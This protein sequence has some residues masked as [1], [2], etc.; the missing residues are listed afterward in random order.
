MI[1]FSA[2]PPT[3]EVLVLEPI[4]TFINSL[5]LGRPVLFVLLTGLVIALVSVTG[6][7]LTYWAARMGGRALIEKLARR[8]WLRLDPRRAERAESL[9]A[10]WG[11][12]LVVFGRIFPGLRTLVSVPAGL[13][14]IPFSQFAGA[15]FIG[16]FAWNTLLVCA[17]YLL[18]FKITL[19]GVSIL[20]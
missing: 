12:R 4:E 10:R 14:P 7:I 20:G 19:L 11:L 17:G 9:F 18:G 1:D 5:V 8:G 3:L 2:K 6:E 13:K 16:A 15:A